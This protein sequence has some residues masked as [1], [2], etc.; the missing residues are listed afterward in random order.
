MIADRPSFSSKIDALFKKAVDKAI[1]ENLSR[2]VPFQY[3]D[4]GRIVLVNRH[5]SSVF[6]KRYSSGLMWKSLCR[7]AVSVKI[8][9]RNSVFQKKSDCAG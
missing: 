8:S 7:S 3:M 5:S 1:H 9:S 4:G 2:D 6:I